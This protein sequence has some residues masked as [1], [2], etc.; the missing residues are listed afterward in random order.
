MTNGTF[1][2]VWRDFEAWQAAMADDACPDCLRLLLQG[3]IDYLAKPDQHA[4]DRLCMGHHPTIRHRGSYAELRAPG[5]LLY[6]Q[7]E[8]GERERE[9]AV[10]VATCPSVQP[11]RRFTREPKH[12]G[13][14]REGLKLRT[15]YASSE[16]ERRRIGLE[17]VGPIETLPLRIG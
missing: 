9:K 12:L 5:L 4:D 11:L 17:S 2:R 6:L 13:L 14:L 1:R 3:R 15:R 7:R 16:I 8:C 10:T